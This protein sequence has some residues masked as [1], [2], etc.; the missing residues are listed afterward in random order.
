MD[1]ITFTLPPNHIL[2][3][4]RITT[5]GSQITI[6]PI[7]S[8]TFNRG[9]IV[10][11]KTGHI[12]ILESTTAEICLLKVAYTEKENMKT[13]IHLSAF[14]MQYATEDEKEYFFDL[15]YN[16]GYS[17]DFDQFELVSYRW[18]PKYGDTYYSV[19][20]EDNKIIPCELTWECHPNDYVLFRKRLVFNSL[21]TC[22]HFI[23]HTLCSNTKSK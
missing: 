13:D 20:V 22:E 3:Q 2:Q 10:K 18:H 17:F 14:D 16:D 23:K 11:T 5:Q 1:P 15:L 6:L 19:F 8:P 9:D 7:I 4:I 12:G 21:E